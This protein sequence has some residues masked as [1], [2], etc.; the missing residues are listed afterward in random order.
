[1]ASSASKSE[2]WGLNSAYG[3]FLRRRIVV[4]GAL[5]LLIAWGIRLWALGAQ[6]LWFD[7]GWS[8]HLAR[9]PLAEMARTTAG[10]RSPPLYYALLHSWI[11]LAGQSEFA[12]R[13]VSALSDT[14]ALAFVL[15]F[16]RAL[17]CDARY[18]FPA[19]LSGL[20]YA[21]CPFAVWYAQETRMYALVAALATAA[22]FFCGNGYA[23]LLGCV[24]WSPG[25]RCWA[26]RSTAITMRSSCCRPM[27]S[28]SSFRL[29]ATLGVRHVGG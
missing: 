8:W 3:A 9:M 14:V 26:A 18:D 27:P 20:A 19:L 24:I 7:E 29:P 16:A 28:S 21:C 25:R 13:F 17:W 4:W 23:L 5:L 11:M 22:T 2:G 12:M 15:A 1:M 10:D 6:S